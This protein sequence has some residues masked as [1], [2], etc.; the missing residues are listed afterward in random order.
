[1]HFVIGMALLAA[2]VSGGVIVKPVVNMYSR[3]SEEADVVSQAICGNNVAII[4][5][6]GGWAHVRTAD[7]YTGWTPASS[8]RK[9]G[10]GERPYASAGRIAQVASLFA[11]LYREPEVTKHQP[12]L[13]VPFE[14]KLEVIREQGAAGRWAEVRLPDK[15]SAFVQ[16]GDIM[17]DAKPMNIRETIEF[18]KRF[19]GLPYFWGGTSAFGFDCSGFMQMLCRRRDIL[20]PRDANVQ[21]TWQGAETVDRERLEPG[22]LLFFGESKV[23]HTGMFIGNG[24]FINATTHEHPVVQISDLADPY[25]TKR[26]LTARRIK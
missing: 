25:W 14:T 2:G 3:P 1:M 18:S 11:N 8:L 21:A 13:T 12:L 10:S 20:I 5:E 15:R 6:Q 23:T 24:Q 7:E 4:E 26:F 17:L 9:L 16:S 22:D 19:L